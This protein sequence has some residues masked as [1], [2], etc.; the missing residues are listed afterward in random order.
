MSIGEIRRYVWLFDDYARLNPD[1][2][3]NVVAIGCGLAGY[4]PEDIAPLFASAPSNVILPP[5]FTEVFDRAG[6]P[7]PTAA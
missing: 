1:F 3:F 2:R 6:C 4:E 5:E 7:R